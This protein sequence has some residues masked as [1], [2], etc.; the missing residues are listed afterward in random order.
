V[1]IAVNRQYGKSDYIPCITWGRNA[2]FT[3]ELMVG[4]NI[5]VWGRIQS[6][7][8]KKKIDEEEYIEKTAYEVSV[9]K[10]EIIKTEDKIGI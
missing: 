8:Y 7:P 6:R 2:K 5:K 10:M 3:S 4:T 1:L 9:T